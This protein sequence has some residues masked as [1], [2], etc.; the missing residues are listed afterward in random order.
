MAMKFKRTRQGNPQNSIPGKLPSMETILDKLCRFRRGLLWRKL[1]TEYRC[2]VVAFSKFSRSGTR[3]SLRSLI[4][5][6]RDV[7]CKL[8]G[9]PLDEH[10]ERYFRNCLGSQCKNHFLAS[11]RNHFSQRFG[12]HIRKMIW[13]TFQVPSQLQE[14]FRKPLQ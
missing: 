10:F 1:N 11:D 7:Y 14:P 5:I 6:Y 13:E 3:H 2:V 8:C 12:T 4:K 9:V